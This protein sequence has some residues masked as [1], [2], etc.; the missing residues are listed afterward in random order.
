MCSRAR[1][2]ASR[3]T[4]TS[5]PATA[6][7]AD[8]PQAHP[9]RGIKRMTI[10]DAPNRRLLPPRRLGG[11]PVPHR[12]RRSG[13]GRIGTERAVDR[14]D[15]L[16]GRAYR[17]SIPP[18]MRTDWPVDGAEI[19]V[20]FH[21]HLSVDDARAVGVD[22][23]AMRCPFLCGGLGEGAH[24][25]LRRAV[26]PERCPPARVA[27]AGRSCLCRFAIRVANADPSTSRFAEF[28]SNGGALFLIFV[29]NPRTVRLC[30]TTPRVAR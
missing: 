1:A 19:A 9:A 14:G 15:C 22:G 17:K 3:S 10:F 8:P 5:W 28:S 30:A 24:P 26:H 18:S 29:A 11:R 21:P 20:D 25:E 16:D 7:I 12:S 2:S 23:D 6:P 4:P 27:A 13:Q